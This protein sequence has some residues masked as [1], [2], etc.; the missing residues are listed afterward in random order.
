[1]VSELTIVL[2]VLTRSK[3]VIMN[4][5]ILICGWVFAV[6]LYAT[7]HAQG[8]TDG[9]LDL[10]EFAEPEVAAPIGERFIEAALNGTGEEFAKDFIAKAIT[11]RYK[12]LDVSYAT[13]LRLRREAQ[14]KSIRIGNKYYI[15]R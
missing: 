4:K 14:L 12:F 3:R 13:I 10:S 15:L 6:S 8:A 5:F 2:N 11:E 7:L 1:M 9:V